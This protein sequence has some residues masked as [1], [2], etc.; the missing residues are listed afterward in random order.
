[1]GWI[2]L[3]KGFYV[4]T[5]GIHGDENTIREYVKV[6]AKKMSTNGYIGSSWRSFNTSQLAARMLYFPIRR[7]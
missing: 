4:N 1:M 7:K 5:V 3:P 2:V 6:R